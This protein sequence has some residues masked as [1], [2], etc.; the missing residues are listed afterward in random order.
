MRKLKIFN[1]LANSMKD[2][3]KIFK[4]FESNMYKLIFILISVTI[5]YSIIMFLIPIF[6]FAGFI[7]DG[8]NE[9][10]NIFQEVE[11]YIED[12]EWQKE[13]PSSP[14]DN[15]CSIYFVYS[16]IHK[17]YLPCRLYTL[18]LPFIE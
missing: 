5:I 2:F 3:L 17:S 1:R 7:G 8:F 15:S 9:M 10:Q 16:S 11:K 12:F 13:H 14:N 6:K 4:W 18:A